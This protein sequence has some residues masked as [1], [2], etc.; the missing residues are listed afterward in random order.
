MSLAG[1]TGA[2]IGEG[3]TTSPLYARTQP[4]TDAPT[5]TLWAQDSTLL[6]WH[7]DNGWYYVSDLAC[8]IF[9]WSSASYIKRTL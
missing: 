8:K 3:V 6:L 7:A 5:V 2:G 1:W 9:G 4:S